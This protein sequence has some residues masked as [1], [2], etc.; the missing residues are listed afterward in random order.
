MQK[1]SVTEPAL[2]RDHTER[3]LRSFGADI[4]S[5][6]NTC[7]ITPPET[8]H[9]QHIEVPG[10]ISSAAFFIVA[11]L[12]TPDSE[13]TIKNVGIN[14]T[15][16]GILK[17]CQDMGADITLLNTHEEGGEPVADLL[18]Q[19]VNFTELLWEEALSLL[20]LMNCLSLPLW[21]ALQKEKPSSKMLTNFV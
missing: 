12:I 21:P 11:G 17:V 10:D 9:G 7:T 14:D 16:A 13:I 15:R 1:T 2:S 5:D 3:M 19:Q 4:V 18:V 20:L 8:L 6:G